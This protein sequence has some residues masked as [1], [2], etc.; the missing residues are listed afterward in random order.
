MREIL[1]RRAVPA[2]H[3]TIGELTVRAYIA[4][5]YLDNERGYAT[6]LRAV[7][8]RAEHTELLVATDD[9][10]TV[11]GSVTLVE[12]GTKYAELSRDGELEFRM[13]AVTPSAHGSG[14]G[15]ELT[16][17]VL[18]RGTELDRNRVVLCSLDRMRPAHRLYERLGF[19]R[20]PE[21]DWQPES[22][23]ELLAYAYELPGK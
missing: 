20:M 7:D 9:T 19:T 23:V 14:V 5:G 2:E 1:I 16:R 6:E 10:G 3:E 8:D 17:A 18:R 12:P 13:L 22:E 21:R 4:G 15:K 11:L